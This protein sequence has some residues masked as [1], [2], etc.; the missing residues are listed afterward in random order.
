MSPILFNFYSEYLTKEAFQIFG[1]HKIAGQEIAMCNIQMT[2]CYWLRRKLED[3]A[4]CEMSLEK[5]KVMRISK[6]QSQLQTVIG[7]KQM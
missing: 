6:K 7:Q 3:S 2:S 1:V 5:S 4:E